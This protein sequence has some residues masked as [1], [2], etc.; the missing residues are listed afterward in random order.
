MKTKLTK[1]FLNS[2]EFKK[3]I[4]KVPKIVK[5]PLSN[6]QYL[7]WPYQKTVVFLHH[8]AGTS[9]QGAIAWWNQT[10]ER[11][12]TPYVIDRNGT[13]FETFDP[14]FWA[15]HLGVRGD[16]DSQEKNS[17]GIELVAAGAIREKM[18][19]PLWPNK[20]GAIKIP[21]EDICQLDKPWVNGSTYHKYT[22][23]QIISLCQ[24]LFKIKADFKSMVYPKSVSNKEF[25]F[26]KDVI[27]KDL[28]GI[29]GHNSVRP[30]KD[31][32]FPQPNLI[33]AINQLL[34]LIK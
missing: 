6:G 14:K 13:I 28:K 10:P 3:E 24:L 30:D 12:G 22:D 15:Y 11:I 1:E 5:S 19:Y 27:A 31:D 9:A 16:D 33:E 26:N 8:T 17:I 20:A 4:T 34:K 7:S 29:Y 25:T 2:E 23:E 21:D 32:I 18:F